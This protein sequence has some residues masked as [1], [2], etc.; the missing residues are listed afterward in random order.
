MVCKEL[1]RLLIHGVDEAAERLLGRIGSGDERGERIGKT[2]GELARE[3][4]GQLRHVLLF[5][6]EVLH[7]GAHTGHAIGFGFLLP[8]PTVLFHTHALV[9]VLGEVV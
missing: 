2:I 9:V 8:L 3:V 1:Q 4:V 6:D 5:V 7:R